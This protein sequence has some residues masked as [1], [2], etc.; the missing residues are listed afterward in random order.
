VRMAVA[1]IIRMDKVRL[2]QAF[3]PRVLTES[4]TSMSGEYII[5][6]MAKTVHIPAVANGALGELNQGVSIM[7]ATYSMAIANAG[8]VSRSSVKIAVMRQPMPMKNFVFPLLEGRMVADP[9]GVVVKASRTFF[10][11]EDANAASRVWFTFNTV[12]FL[13]RF[14]GKFSLM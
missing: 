14:N 3:P 12:R 10:S 11:L 6:Q 2:A 13:S 4:S 1:Q 7:G 9:S 8:V 5:P